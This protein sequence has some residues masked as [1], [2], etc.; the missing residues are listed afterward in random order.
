M[1]FNETIAQRIRGSLSG[2]KDISEKK[3]FGGLCFM[4]EGKM[5][6]GVEKDQLFLRV[7]P[8]EGEELLKKAGVKPFVHG[9]MSMKGFLL[10]DQSAFKTDEQLENWLKISL[11]YV[12]TLPAKK[13][14]K[15][16]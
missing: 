9:G 10:I 11:E 4:L 15:L 16:I 13:V 6:C 12:T 7:N 14:N 5:V 1:A 8:I 3:M 2:V